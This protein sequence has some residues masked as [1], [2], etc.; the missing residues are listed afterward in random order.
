MNSK[1]P[2]ILISTLLWLFYGFFFLNFGKFQD[3]GWYTCAARALLEGLQP[4]VDFYYPHTP[5]Y[6]WIYSF[7]LDFLPAPN[8]WW[9][10]F[11]HF[12]LSTLCLVFCLR[13][14]KIA[15]RTNWN[16]FLVI[17]LINPYFLYFLFQIK[18]YAICQILLFGSL[19]LWIESRKPA[20]YF[21]L[22]LV[23]LTRISFFPILLV[24]LWLDRKQLKPSYFLAYG[25]P[26]LTL[27]FW[28]WESMA[29]NLFF[30]IPIP[31]HTPNPFNEAYFGIQS[32]QLISML[33]DKVGFL[34]RLMIIFT[35]F[36]IL[37]RH[38]KNSNVSR[39]LLWVFWISVLSHVLALKPLDEYLSPVFIPLYF[40]LF[41]HYGA[42]K[43]LRAWMIV[44]IILSGAHTMVRGIR[45]FVF[46]SQ[47]QQIESLVQKIR[48]ASAGERELLLS[49]DGYVNSMLPGKIQRETIMARFSF[50]PEFEPQ[51][52]QA[53]HVVHP[54]DV[55]RWIGEKRFSFL[56][57]STSEM[58]SFNLAIAGFSDLLRRHY[59]MEQSFE[60]LT[61]TEQESYLWRVKSFD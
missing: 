38:L 18:S 41:L 45:R 46:P 56:L 33:K 30:P 23:S 17:I 15:G 12:L 10:R 60:N 7:L 8:P 16:W 19:Y 6:L 40:L 50:R 55:E 2:L 24:Y 27:F 51:Q 42:P 39:L 53:L 35:P 52:A 21:L 31:G 57:L 58:D 1:T 29:Q 32:P 14:L 20:A 28:P 37:I 44:L 49:F 11:L 36:L 26:L 34:L 9:G 22:S 47:I 13:K 4:Y 59:Q 54:R 5:L 43:R 3:G 61:E 25:L 48:A